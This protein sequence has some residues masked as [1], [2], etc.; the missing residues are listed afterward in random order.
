MKYTQIQPAKQL[1]PYIRCYG[2]LENDRIPNKTTTF[3]IIADGHPGFIFQEDTTSFLDKDSNRLPQLFLHG[4]TT[5]HSRK[6]SQGN[7]RNIGV[8]LQPNAVKSIF[9]IDA[10]E[11]TDQFI[12]VNA[13]IKNSLAEQLL[14]ENSIERRIAIISDFIYQQIAKNKHQENAKTTY[15]IAKINTESTSEL[16]RIQSELNLSERT[17]ERI[18]K[19][20]VG[21]SP[22]LFFRICRFQAALDD[23]RKRTAATLTEIAYQHSYADQSHFIREFKEFAGTIPKQF[24]LRANEQA[25]NFPEWKS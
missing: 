9:G 12:D 17:L 1:Q 2:I 16:N 20:D 25:L 13:I 6:T 15:A 19:T 11:L 21:I 23:I 3:K 8:Y 5:N 24:L 18:F 7:Y 10:N 14:C 22:K 4:I